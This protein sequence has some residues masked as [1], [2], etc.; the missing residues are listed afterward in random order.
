[1]EHDARTTALA[2]VVREHGPAVL[3][4]VAAGVGAVAGSFAVAGRLPGFV[5]APV[6]EVVVA[7]TPDVIIRYS[8]LLLGS[9]GD[10]LAF[11]LALALTALLFAAVVWTVHRAA[12]AVDA[13]R[14]DAPVA[15]TTLSLVAVLLFSFA[16]GGDAASALG[17][18]VG[19]SIPLGVATLASRSVEPAPAGRRAALG[20]LAAAIGL[21]FAGGVLGSRRTV[22]AGDADATVPADSPEGQLL[23]MARD[24]SLDVE[25]LEPLVSDEFYTVDINQVDPTPDPDEW[26]LSVTGAVEMEAEYTYDDLTSRDPEHRFN[27]LRCVGERL[28]GKKMDNA[29]WTGTPLMDIVEAANPQGEYVML[30]AADGFFE[31]FSVSALRSGFLAYGMNGAPLPRGHGAP[32]RALIPGHWGEINVKWLTE[33]EILDEPMD[34]YW[35][36]RGWHGTG[37]VETVAKLHVINRLDDGRIEV[38]GHAYAGTRG[39]DR[40]EVSVD[41]GETWTD[42]S[43]S[44]PLPGDDVWRQWVHRYDSPGTE[45]EVVV[46]ATDG[47]GTL[48][49]EDE[50]GSFPNGPAGWVSR[51]VNA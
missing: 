24:N 51:T 7:A 8:I 11:L 1:M 47:T 23:G 10:S 4:A 39:V 6:A 46:R 13:D 21:V 22:S 31:E 17:A 35:E 26:T 36:Q 34:G 27:T 2:A 12:A 29:L 37:P 20:S 50:R 3:L 44:E 25:G 41:G 49:P 16:L 38:A 15:A 45:H 14:F 18:T 42:A 40:V 28:N 30:R 9:L 43:L 48:Q 32:V 33:I 19:A 5:A